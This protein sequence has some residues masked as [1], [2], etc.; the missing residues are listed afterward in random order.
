VEFNDLEIMRAI[1][2]LRRVAQLVPGAYVE[3]QAVPT[4]PD[5]NMV[6]AWAFPFNCSSW[7]LGTEE[8]RT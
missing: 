1:R 2:G 5:D 6:V 8:E 7:L 4:Y 3:L